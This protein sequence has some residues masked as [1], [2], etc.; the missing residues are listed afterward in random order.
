MGDVKGIERW[1]VV[2]FVLKIMVMWRRSA[3]T[4]L[5]KLNPVA[6]PHIVCVV[7]EALGCDSVQYGYRRLGEACYPQWQCTRFWLRPARF[8][9]VV[10]H[11]TP[12][13]ISDTCSWLVLLYFEL[14]PTTLIQVSM[15]FPTPC[16]YSR[17]VHEIS[18]WYVPSSS[19]PLCY[20][21]PSVD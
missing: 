17:I 6:K 13:R 4:V 20:L 12:F 21:L 14:T 18:S 2:I 15:V 8:H 1:T 5:K 11:G 3:V 7:C 9:V 19:F 16:R 10:S